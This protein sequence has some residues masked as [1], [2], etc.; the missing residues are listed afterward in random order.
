[1]DEGSDGFFEEEMDDAD[2]SMTPGPAFEKEIKRRET[3]Q[4]SSSA[5]IPLKDINISRLSMQSR[6]QLSEDDGDLARDITFNNNI[7]GRS[8]I[9]TTESM[10]R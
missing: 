10:D 1:M 3:D 4:F 7:R 5:N 6:S 9:L 2:Q 8:K